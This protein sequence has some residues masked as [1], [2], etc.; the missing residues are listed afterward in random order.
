[1]YTNVSKENHDMLHDVIFA[2]SQIVKLSIMLS[3]IKC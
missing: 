2:P 1:M 3:W